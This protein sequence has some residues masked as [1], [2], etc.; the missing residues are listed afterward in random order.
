MRFFV[1]HFLST[2]VATCG[3]RITDSGSDDDDATGSF[4]EAISANVE[5]GTADV[6]TGGIFGVML[7]CRDISL[8]IIIVVFIVFKEVEDAGGWKTQQGRQSIR[9]GDVVRRDTEVAEVVEEDHGKGGSKRPFQIG[10]E[11]LKE[12]DNCSIY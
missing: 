6:A 5:N 1:A 2:G 7:P 8:I 12:D 9:T 4:F 11:Q 10:N 3:G